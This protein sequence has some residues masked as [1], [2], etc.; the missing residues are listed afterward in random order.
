MDIR[1]RA[2]AY[3]FEP[4]TYPGQP[5]EFLTKRLQ[6][7][8]MPYIAEHV[9]DGEYVGEFDVCVVEIT[10]IDTVQLTIEKTDYMEEGVPLGSDEGRFLLADAGVKF[11]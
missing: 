6:A 3:G 5:G 1:E 11:D 2:K 4:T 7:G 9:V 8:Q 10:P